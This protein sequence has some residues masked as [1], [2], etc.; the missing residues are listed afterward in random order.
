MIREEL[1]HPITSH[2][3]IA[4]LIL[5]IFTKLAQLFVIKTSDSWHE[6]LDFLNKFLLFTGSLM[7]LPTIF[8]GDM[9]FDI[10]KSEMK[11][12]T[13]AY[14]H[15]ELAHTTLYCFIAVLISEVIPLLKPISKNLIKMYLIFQIALIGIGN[16]Y[17]FETAH[18]GATMVYDYGTAV[19][20]KIN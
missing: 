15:D 18:S 20:S 19:K 13:L 14:K 12:I 17:L 11:N 7:L 8:L 10:V 6:K 3:P 1:L 16:Y 4:L 9:A 2:F 5:L